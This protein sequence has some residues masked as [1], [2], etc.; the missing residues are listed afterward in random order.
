MAT[1][2]GALIR[3]QGQTFAIAVVKNHVLTSDSS[4]QRAARSFAAIFGFGVPIVLMG[5]D[6]KLWGRQDIVRFLSHV[7][8][9]RI[10]WK[11]Y[12]VS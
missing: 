6:G 8:M 3:E 9:D 7:S 12:T 5:E 2:Q 10:P 11:R 4:R 1:F